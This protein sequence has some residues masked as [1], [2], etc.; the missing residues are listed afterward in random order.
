[1]HDCFHHLPAQNVVGLWDEVAS[2]WDEQG[3]SFVSVPA[4]SGNGKGMLGKFEDAGWV[5]IPFSAIR[6]VLRHFSDTNFVSLGSKIGQECRGAPQ[7]D[8]LSS[9]VLRLF[10][11]SRENAKHSEEA[12][13]TIM[14]PGGEYF[15]FCRSVLFTQWKHVG[16]YAIS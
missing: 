12:K 7:G 11:W 9:A 15:L 16:Q 4:K 14:F 13:S 8:A 2:F 5:A 6:L 1:M 3:I 10:K